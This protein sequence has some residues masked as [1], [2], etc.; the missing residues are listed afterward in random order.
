VSR[1]LVA[2]V[3]LLIGV[4]LGYLLRGSSAS[5][6]AGIAEVPARPDSA[7]VLT[8]RGDGGAALRAG[9]EQRI[10]LG[11][12][13][14]LELEREKKA[15]ERR[16]AD[17]QTGREPSTPEESRDALIRYYFADPA[18]SRDELA[19]DARLAAS[20]GG[21]F[22]QLVVALHD[23]D[24]SEYLSQVFEAKRAVLRKGGVQLSDEEA[25][26]VRAAFVETWTAYRTWARSDLRSSAANIQTMED[27]ARINA[28]IAERLGRA[29][30]EVPQTVRRRAPGLSATVLAAI[31]QW[32]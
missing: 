13:R 7:P 17:A 30:H 19:A 23:R 22:Q 15:L 1:L 21:R 2:V 29:Y 28:L 31:D 8:G 5:D 14:V 18:L 6:A 10:R 26:V 24:V 27:R 9:L 11:E 32:L 4:G 20:R 25:A 3:C 12:A 16:L